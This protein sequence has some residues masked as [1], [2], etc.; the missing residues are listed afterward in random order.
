MSHLITLFPPSNNNVRLKI[1][2]TGAT[3]FIGSQLAR[4]LVIDGHELAVLVRPDSKLDV[5][6]LILPQI[7]VHFYN[8]SYASLLSAL[9]VIRPNVVCHIASLFLAQHKSEDVARLIES[10]LNFP[11]QL[12]EAMNQVG[13]KNLINTG[14]SWQHFQNDFYN[15]VNLYAATKQAFEALLTYYVE[16]H[17]FKTITLKLFD[18]YGPGDM[19]PKLFSLLRNAARTGMVLRMSPGEQMLDLVY[20]DDVLDAF[21]LAIARLIKGGKTEC[22]AVSNL[23]R[24]SLRE[25]INVYSEVV[26]RRL[27]VEWGGLHYRSREVLVPWT[28]HVLVPGWQ[29]KISLQE[30]I[31]RMEQD[32]RIG[33]LLA[34]LP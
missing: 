32:G 13:I 21:L 31:L 11:T 2:L 16:A 1:L 7:Q 12:L 30:G 14:T 25:L 5:L 18:T 9:E 17:N 27:S 29:P 15:P 6:Q 26:G 34:K 23:Q 33:G 3:G 19:R 8:G 22:C 4:R 20:I 24:L 10:N 28:N